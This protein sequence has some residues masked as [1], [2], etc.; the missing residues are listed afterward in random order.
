[1]LAGAPLTMR[2]VLVK[3]LIPVTL[4]NGIAGAALV[5]ASFSFAFGKLGEGK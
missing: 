4:G 2:D 5:A 1:M 3:N